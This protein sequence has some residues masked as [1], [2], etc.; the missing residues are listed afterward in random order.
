MRY[1]FYYPRWAY[2]AYREEFQQQADA[3]GWHYLDTWN[4]VPMQEFTNSAI[5]LTP[6]GVDLMA[7]RIRSSL[8]TFQCN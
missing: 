5:H 6:M 4:T 8:K 1:N 3:A 7:E 2:D